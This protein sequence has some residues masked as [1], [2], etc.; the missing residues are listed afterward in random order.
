MSPRDGVILFRSGQRLLRDSRPADGH[1]DVDRRPRRH[2]RQRHAADHPGQLP[3]A[4]GALARPVQR[5]PHP[6]LPPEER[7]LDVEQPAGGV[8]FFAYG[9]PHATGPNT[10][11]HKRAGVALHFLRAD[12][13]QDELIA[14]DRDYRP[15]LTGPQATGGVREYGETVAGT[16]EREVERALAQ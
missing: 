5:S 11:D 15:F 12:Y 13:A 14:P 3:R 9:T 4:V 1:G 2:R 8:V 16:W 10:A 6:L 7:V